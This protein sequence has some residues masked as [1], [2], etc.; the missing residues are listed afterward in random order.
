MNTPARDLPL[1]ETVDD[2][3]DS[4]PCGF[5]SM[6]PDGTITQV[7]ATFLAWTGHSRATLLG[8]KRFQDLLTIPGRI[9]YETHFAPLLRMQGFV[10]EIACQIKREGRDPLDVIIS[11]NLKLGPSGEPTVIRTVVF[12]ATDRVK[13]EEELRRVR[14]SAQQLAAIV[15]SSSDAIVSIGFDDVVRSWNPAATSLFGYGE[16]DAVG[17]TVDELIVPEVMRDVRLQNFGKLRSGESVVIKDTVRRRKDGSLVPVEII[18]SPVRDAEGRVGAVAL[19]FRNI[20]ERK[21]TEAALRASERR[22]RLILDGTLAFIGVMECDGT[23]IEANAPALAAG[24]LTREEALNRKLWDTYWFNH[25]PSVMEQVQR[26]VARALN[27]DLVREDLEVR[28][29]GDTRMT[30]DFM[31]SPIRDEEGLISLLV[32]SGFDITERK[33]AETALKQSHDTYLRLIE[34]NPFGV[35]LINSDFRVV[36]F[37]AGVKKV[38]AHTPSL[39]GQDLADIVLV[40]WQEPFASEVVAQFRHTL[41]TGETYHSTALGHQRATMEKVASYDWQIMRVKMPNGEFGVVCYFYDT[42]EIQNYERHIKLLMGEVNHRSKNLLAVVQAITRQ[43]ARTTDPDTFAILLSER[44]RGLAASQDLLVKNQ[45][46]NVAVADLVRAQLAHFNNMIGTRVLME[47]PP[48]HLSASSAQGIG[49]ALHELAT[50][51]LKHGAL[52]NSSGRIRIYWENGFA[53]EPIF[54][55]HWLEEG[56]P[57]VVAPTRKGF[58]NR[59]IERM[60]EEAVGGKV[61]IEYRSSGLYWKLTAPSKSL[62]AHAT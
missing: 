54:V 10:K 26:A 41:D 38:F 11:S 20:T 59:V 50:N 14:G 49:M 19:I 23:L 58:G 5:I 44:I 21:R 31:L 22:L 51:A 13:Y 32:P 39:L 30:I 56:G 3:L 52:S 40:L 53:A 27:G 33:R 61:E 55:M 2:V 37:S 46:T 1:E 15:M 43:T 60:A 42:T 45:W 25:D 35:Y 29:R 34:D 9:F 17:R 28:M 16:E 57:E 8:D 36:Q 47:G 18:A 6:M 62:G 24:G 48:V 7:N 4:A 12:D